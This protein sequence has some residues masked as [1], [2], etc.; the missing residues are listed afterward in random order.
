MKIQSTSSRLYKRPENRCTSGRPQPCK[1]NHA[2]GAEKPQREES[3]AERRKCTRE[4]SRQ[5]ELRGLIAVVDETEIQSS[6]TVTYV[7]VAVLLMENVKAA[8]SMCDLVSAPDRI[9]PFHWK[10]EGPK[11]R[12]GSRQLIREHAVGTHVLAQTTTL[13]GNEDARAALMTEMLNR[14]AI[15]GVDH[16]TRI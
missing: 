11:N 2:L 8:Q 6:D 15:G 14:L 13:G 5:S 10:D 7:L 4:Q 9:R 12:D 1:L 16:L 3:R